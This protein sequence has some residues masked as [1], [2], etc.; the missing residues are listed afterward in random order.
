MADTENELK[1]KLEQMVYEMDPIHRLFVLMIVF[2]FLTVVTIMATYL[3]ISLNNCPTPVNT[4]EPK[5]V[6]VDRVIEKTV[7]EPFSNCEIQDKKKGLKY[8]KTTERNG[9]IYEYYKNDKRDIWEFYT[10]AYK[11]EYYNG[12]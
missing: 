1:C 4:T 11:K 3:T 12:N 8:L 7:Y 2:G 10:V 6:Y 9:R 5:I